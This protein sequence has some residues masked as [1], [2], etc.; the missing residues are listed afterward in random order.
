MKGAAGLR[1]ARGF[2]KVVA[3]AL[4]ASFT[5]TVIAPGIMDRAPGFMGVATPMNK[6]IRA[7]R[8]NNSKNAHQGY[9]ECA[10]RREQMANGRLRYSN[11]G[12]LDPF[13]PFE[14]YPVNRIRKLTGRLV[15][16]DGTPLVG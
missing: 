5:P 6:C 4:A 11:S 10:R 9:Q 8:R 2:Y 15:S 12:H 16:P 14:P 1:G 3:T 13:E 7:L